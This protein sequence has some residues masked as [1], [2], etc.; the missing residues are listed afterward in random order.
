MR[1]FSVVVDDVRPIEGR[2]WPASASPHRLTADEGKY[3]VNISHR[4]ALERKI[5]TYELG[6]RAV[7]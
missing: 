7:N 3:P 2:S 5:A 1:S 6:V 4:D